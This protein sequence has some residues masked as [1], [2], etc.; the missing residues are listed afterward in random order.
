MLK[1]SL[2]AV[3]VALTI[4]AFAQAA[5]ATGASSTSDA[6]ADADVYSGTWAA[7]GQL[8]LIVTSGNTTT[9]S[10]NASFDAAHRIDR[11]T[12]S[13]GFGALYAS[14]GHYSTQ[15]DTNA[16][17]QADFAL[18]PR[19]FWFS[20]ARWD[21]NLFT[22]FAYQESVASG[23]GFKF[24]QTPSTLLAAELGVGYRIQKPETLTIG[25]LGNIDSRV[26][27]PGS[28]VRDAVLQA[29]VNYSHSITES[30]KV[31]NT[32]LVQYGASDTT[33]TDSLSLQVKVDAT[34][35]LAVGMQLV[36]NTSPPPGTIGS[37]AGSAGVRHTDTVLTVNLVYALKNK[38]LSASGGTPISVAGFNLP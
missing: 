22:G 21:R 26:R 36:S 17:V 2:A 8:G 15:Q 9:K 24:I 32:L 16:H 4:N 29:G 7:Q 30:T 19:T 35:S 27:I 23:G 11:W 33:T 20:T 28:M 6:N 12:L 37:P 3:A 31:V 25:P 38:D 10:G 13:G 5:G 34:L 14:S 18:S 1:K